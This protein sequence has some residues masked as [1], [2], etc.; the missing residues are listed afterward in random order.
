VRIRVV[1]VERDPVGARRL[2]ALAEARGIQAVGVPA[3][4]IGDHLLVGLVD[5]ETTGRAIVALLPG[6]MLAIAAVTLSGRRLQQRGGRWLKLLSG[7][8]MLALGLLLI[9][10]PEWLR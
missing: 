7:A 1:D 6:I 9:A 4:L 5:A 8:V 2:R 10:K 3:F